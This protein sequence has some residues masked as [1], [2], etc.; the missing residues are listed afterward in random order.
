MEVSTYKTGKNSYQIKQKGKNL[1]TK[2]KRG[3]EWDDIKMYSD[4]KMKKR[5]NDY[6]IFGRGQYGN[7]KLIFNDLVPKGFLKIKGGS[8]NMNGVANV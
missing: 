1:V 7:T 6:F 8:I 2:K 5:P 4:S 3:S